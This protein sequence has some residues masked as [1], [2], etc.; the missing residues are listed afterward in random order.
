MFRSSDFFEILYNYNDTNL[1]ALA[2]Q[3][4]DDILFHITVFSKAY[5]SPLSMIL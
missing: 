3:I 4:N 5:N 2:I 1:V